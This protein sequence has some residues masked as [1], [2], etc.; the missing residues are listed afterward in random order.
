MPRDTPTGN[1]GEVFLAFLR[2]GC[3]AFGGPVAHL[4]YFREAFVDRRRWLDERAYAEL[5]ALA[6]TL[7]GPASSQV[8]MALGLTRAGVPGA[9]AAWLGFTLPSALIMAGVAAGAVGARGM[10]GMGWLHGLQIAAVAVVA[11]ALWG[12]AAR[13]C[14]DARRASFA[15]AAAV[16]VT[17]VPGPA[18]QLGA[19]GL[20]ALAGLAFLRAHAVEPG[21]GDLPVPLS[22]TTGAAMLVAFA[23]ILA[24]LP[25]VA[26]AAEGT[27]LT[28]ADA[29]YRAGALVFGGGH[30]V[31]PLL[32]AEVVPTGLMDR[33]SFLAGYGAAQALPGPLFTFGG[34]LGAVIGGPL[35]ALAALLGIFLPGFLLMLGALPFWARLRRGTTATAALTGVNAAVV[36]LLAAA[37]YDPLWTNTIHRPADFAVA[38]TAF[39]LLTA[40]RVPPAVVVG[41]CALAGGGLAAL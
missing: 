1:A 23:I 17:A 37:L 26:A 20:A 39:L 14:P 21:A 7:P 25:A 41:L 8:G 10:L 28:I 15:V 34:Y 32:Q 2:L 5:V 35:G 30:V 31:L 16:L 12:M 11:R 29:A 9:L 4:G 18:G 27:W 38:L 36:G 13:L 33:E 22:R 6:Q 24:G 3:T 40:W 19:I